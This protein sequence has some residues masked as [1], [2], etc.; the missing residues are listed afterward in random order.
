[1]ARSIRGNALRMLYLRDDLRQERVSF[2]RT[3]YPP[4]KVS[5]FMTQVNGETSGRSITC[6]SSLETRLEG[7]LLKLSSAHPDYAP[8]GHRHV[9]NVHL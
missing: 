9:R 8:R 1:M 6:K 7:N 5:L 3:C 2:H 4:I